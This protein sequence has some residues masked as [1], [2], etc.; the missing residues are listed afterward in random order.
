MV[1][2]D[3]WWHSQ[4]LTETAVYQKLILMSIMVLYQKINKLFLHDWGIKLHGDVY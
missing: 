2:V 3:S 1:D 4:V